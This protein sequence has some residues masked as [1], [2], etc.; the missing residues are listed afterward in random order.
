MSRKPCKHSNDIL[1]LLDMSN[2]AKKREVQLSIQG[3]WQR[4][5]FF[6]LSPSLFFSSSSLQLA[7]LLF[8]YD[9]TCKI[10]KRLKSKL[11]VTRAHGL[12][13]TKGSQSKLLDD[14]PSCLSG[15]VCRNP[16][17]TSHVNIILLYRPRKQ[18]KKTG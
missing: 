7:F 10:N 16:R 2:T 11:N 12:L 6:F 14:A 3:R 1:H 9:I 15:W 18:L 4:S 17:S 5:S 8:S 13:L